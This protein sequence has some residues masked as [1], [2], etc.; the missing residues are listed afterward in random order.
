M[1]NV[2]C[3][4]RKCVSGGG[5]G[6]SSRTVLLARPAAA[7]AVANGNPCSS[8]T[9]AGIHHNNIKDNYEEK[10]QRHTKAT[11]AVSQRGGASPWMGRAVA[12]LPSL[13][14]SLAPGGR[15]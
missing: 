9:K 14:L 7:A 10:T 3:A 8:V 12:S 11:P 6:S 4:F 13:S 15:M 2:E 5:S 1:A